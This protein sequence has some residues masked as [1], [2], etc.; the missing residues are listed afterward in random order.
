MINKKELTWIIISIII[1]EFILFFPK[2]SSI[3]PQGVLAPI[4]IILVYILSKKI[5][6]NY[7]NIKVEHKIWEFQRYGWLRTSKLE[8]PFEIGLV[9]PIIITRSSGSH[10]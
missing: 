1:F 6:A 2:S 9:L 3:T 4:L 7:F 5:A 8:K 10:P